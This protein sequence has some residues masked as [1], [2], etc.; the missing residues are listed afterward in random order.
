MVVYIKTITQIVF[1]S[2]KYD[3]VNEKV[4]SHKSSQKVYK[5]MHIQKN[6]IRPRK[7]C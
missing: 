6:Y 5:L 1:I 2:D 4:L 7:E 3:F